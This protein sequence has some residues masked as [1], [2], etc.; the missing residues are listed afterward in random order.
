MKASYPKSENSGDS[1]DKRFDMQWFYWS[2]GNC[3]DIL[4]SHPVS[5]KSRTYIAKKGIERPGNDAPGTPS[6][7]FYSGDIIG[8]VVDYITN[9]QPTLTFL[10]NGT[11]AHQFS[12]PKELELYLAVY[13]YN[14][15]D[16]VSIQHCPQDKYDK[17]LL[18]LNNQA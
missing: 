18:A 9:D 7:A 17:Q 4:G 16:S 2:D 10:L 14:A 3:W 5:A 6:L 12:V 15:N 8:I 13:F 11:V 1:F